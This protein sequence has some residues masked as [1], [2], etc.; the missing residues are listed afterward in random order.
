MLLAISNWQLADSR[1]KKSG[2]ILNIKGLGQ[3]VTRFYKLPVANSQSLIAQT[4]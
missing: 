3:I 2:V 4:V 1:I